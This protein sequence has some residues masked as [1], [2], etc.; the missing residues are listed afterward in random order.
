MPSSY[1]ALVAL[2]A[3]AVGALAVAW[4]VC[5][6]AVMYV[7]ADVMYALVTVMCG[8]LAA[9][10]CGALAAAMCGA[11]AAVMWMHE[12]GLGLHAATCRAGQM[13]LWRCAHQSVCHRHKAHSHMCCGCTP[14]YDLFLVGHN[15]CILL[16]D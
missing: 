15:R 12:P 8:A 4:T 9:A 6:L 2:V 1:V 5:A 13:D 11:C 10:M 7:L 3:A 14:S 16:G